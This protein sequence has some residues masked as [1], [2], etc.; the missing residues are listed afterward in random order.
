MLGCSS[1]GSKRDGHLSGSSV[2]ESSAKSG[3][4]SVLLLMYGESKAEVPGVVRSV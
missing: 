4:V 3:E 2:K 1:I